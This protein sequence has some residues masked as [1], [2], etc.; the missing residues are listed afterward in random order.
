MKTTIATIAAI[1]LVGSIA[2]FVNAEGA[3][4]WVKNNAGWWA[5]GTISESEFIQGIQ[6]LIKDGII[7][8]P[9]TTVSA[10]KSQSVPAWVK[11]NAGWWA[12]GTITD[13]QFI[14]GIQHLIK[15]G[16]ISLPS[17]ESKSPESA[18]KTTS[19]SKS[20][21]Y[22]P[23]TTSQS[24]SPEYTPKTTSQSKSPESAPKTTSDGSRLAGLQ[25]NL[26]KC[27]DIFQTYARFDCVDKAKLEITEYEYEQ[28]STKY[29]VGPATYYYPGAEVE[30]SPN[31]QALLIIK[32]LVKNTGSTN[33][34]SLFCTGPTVCNYDVW[35][36]KDVFRYSTNDFTNGN[37]VL[38]PGD[39]REFTM[40]FGP[41]IPIPGSTKFIYDPAKD[42]DFRISEPWGSATIPL[43]LQ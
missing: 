38:T 5:D 19:Q 35:N 17:S 8:I 26:D 32:M 21:E 33:N 41:M 7:V 22:T 9:P 39:S 30:I 36:G 23:K 37:I 43:N 2:P 20:P 29:V 34:V 11:N 40:L 25:A 42:Y 24:K 12:D 1:L 18:P 16:V 28:K 6:F 14:N 10:E 13:T 31:G 4:A 15:T 3:P 27:K